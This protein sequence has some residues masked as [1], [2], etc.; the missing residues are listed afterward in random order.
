MQE[1]KNEQDFLKRSEDVRKKGFLPLNE[2]YN[3]L[4]HTDQEEV[5]RCP[6]KYIITDLLEPC[7][8]LWGKNIFTYMTSDYQDDCVWIAIKI[9]DL[10]PENIDYIDSLEKTVK[11]FG[12]EEECI[13]IG[14]NCK[15]GEARLRLAN[16]ANGFKMQDV[17]KS[18]T[19]TYEEAMIFCGCFKEEINPNYLT[20]EKYQQSFGQLSYGHYHEYLDSIYGKKTIKRVDTSKI[21]G[22]EEVVLKKHHFAQYNGIIYKSPFYLQKHLRYINYT[23]TL[24]EIMKMTKRK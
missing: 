17:P 10:S 5:E 9:N 11:K 23:S 21:K 7:Y 20:L 8:I 24:E 4:P 18:A 12:R 15:G 1:R 14:V 13:H 2:K 19:I 22:K 3:P 6:E 16:I